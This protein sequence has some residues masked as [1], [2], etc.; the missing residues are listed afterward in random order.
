[1]GAETSLSSDVPLLRAA[2]LPPNPTSTYRFWRLLEDL[3]LGK[4]VAGAESVCSDGWSE[5][6]TLCRLKTAS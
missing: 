6:S 4:P 3:L 2:V 1:V 5:L